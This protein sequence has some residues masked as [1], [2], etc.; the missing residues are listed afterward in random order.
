MAAA[1]ENIVEA[2]VVKLEAGDIL[3]V[4]VEDADV[5]VDEVLGAFDRAIEAAGLDGQV[6]CIIHDGQIRLE[7]I[8][9]STD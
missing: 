4:H 8:R 5:P 9:C 2:T 6:G 7:V 3:I 1:D